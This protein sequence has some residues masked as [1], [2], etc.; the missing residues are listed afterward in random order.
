MTSGGLEETIVEDDYSI[1]R[2]SERQIK[3]IDHVCQ[4]LSKALEIDKKHF[5]KIF[6][7]IFVEMQ[8]RE[9][10]YRFEMAQ[11]LPQVKLAMKKMI[12]PQLKEMII[13]FSNL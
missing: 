2:S 6:D 8:I 11:D 1:L 7:K 9:S 3:G 13:K 4:R 10:R 12:E 5:Q